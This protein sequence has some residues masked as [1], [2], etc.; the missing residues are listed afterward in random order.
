L[1]ADLHTHTTCSDGTL[2]PQ[3]LILAAQD[4]QLDVLSI[5]DHDTLQAYGELPKS[6]LTIIPG[7]EFSSQLR[8]ISV[9]ILGYSFQLD[10]SGLQQFLKEQRQR[11]TER[12]EQ[13]VANLH[14]LGVPIP[15]EEVVAAGRGSIGRPH[16]AKVLLKAGFVGSVQKAFD[17]YLGDGKPA[18]AGGVRPS[19]AEV[20]AVLHEAGGFAV[21]AHPHFIRDRAL[22]HEVL[23]E[24]FDGLEAHYALQPSAEWVRI[25]KERGLFVT[26]GSDFHGAIKPNYTLGAS[27]APEST[28]RILLKE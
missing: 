8:G 19:I 28:V 10:H 17:L 6:A 20:I 3:E 16:I 9:H 25:A 12:N 22:L 7:I 24:P 27:L 15:L 14:R 13:I 1:R 18:Y 5:T 11:R 4:A 21:L 23:Q 2:T 26:G